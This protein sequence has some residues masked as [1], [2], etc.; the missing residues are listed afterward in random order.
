MKKLFF[1]ILLFIMM[2]IPS[3]YADEMFKIK[4]LDIDT[5]ASVFFVNTIGTYQTSI[6]D[7]IKLV[8][9][10]DEKKVYFDIN[11]A[12]LTSK[13]Q[14]LFLTRGSV[15]Q[16]KISQFTTNP[17]VVRVVLQF[18]DDYDLANLKI[19]NIDNHLIIMTSHFNDKS[20]QFYQNVYRDKLKLSEDY[21]NTLKLEIKSNIPPTGEAVKGVAQVQQAF[22]QST[23]EEYANFLKSPLNDNI[24]LRSRYYIDEITPIKEGFKITGYGAPTLQ[25]PFV[26][27]NPN[28]MVFDVANADF[29]SKYYNTELS[30]TPES[31]KLRIARFDDNLTRIVINS[32]DAKQYLPIFSSD[33][34]SIW[35]VNPSK[36]SNNAFTANKTNIV[37]YKYQKNISTDDL[38]LRFDKPVVWG[39]KRNADNLYVYFIYII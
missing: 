6:T 31:D 39:I 26:L 21:Y 3:A 23:G 9:L 38:T 35:L 13:K 1:I 4:G 8:K 10:E 25:R 20:C 28:R 2:L 36:L 29:N 33:N 22:S 30:L 34:Q 24:L 18:H 37:D 11:S 17:N 15:K 12:I 32:D 14:D 16:I 5:S 7:S 19:G 27:T